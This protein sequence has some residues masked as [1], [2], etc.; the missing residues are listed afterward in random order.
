MIHRRSDPERLQTRFVM[1][2]LGDHFGL[3]GREVPVKDPPM[4]D[5]IERR[6]ITVQLA[7]RIAEAIDSGTWADRLPGKRTLAKLYGVNIKTCAAAMALL[8]KRCLISPGSAGRERVILSKPPKKKAISRSNR[9]LLLLHQADAALNLEDIQLFRRMSEIWSKIHGDVFWVGV[10]YPRYRRPGPML[11]KLIQRHSAS[12]L[13][14]HMSWDNWCREALKRVPTY[15]A[16]GTRDWDSEGSSGA[17]S[18]EKDTIR[19]LEHLRKLG[20]RRILTPTLAWDDQRWRF[21]CSYLSKDWD[22]PPPIGIWEDYCPRFVENAPEVWDQYWKKAFGAVRPTAVILRDDSL[23]LS[24]YGYCTTVGLR[25]PNDV[26]VVLLS[27]DKLW[28]YLKPR[29]TMLRYPVNTAAAHFQMWVDNDLH[30]IGR[31]TFALE[32]VEGNSVAP[33]SMKP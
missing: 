14:L 29:P 31:K 19:V 21:V 13:M 10:D 6:T 16:G 12:A 20:H 30:P 17:S 18:M 32:W 27:H 2:H 24:L 7:D 25:I 22:E 8:E 1:V 15:Q 33:A 3:D 28:G 9:V 23:L 4:K 5:E 26:S 11:D